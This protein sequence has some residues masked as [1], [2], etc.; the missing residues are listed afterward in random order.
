MYLLKEAA[1]T[2]DKERAQKSRPRKRRAYQQR[3]DKSRDPDE[4]EDEDEPGLTQS[5]QA[6]VIRQLHDSRM[7]K[8]TWTS[9]DPSTQ[10]AWDTIVDKDKAAILSYAEQRGAKHAQDKTPLEANVHEGEDHDS[11]D[12]EDEEKGSPDTER[13][14]NVTEGSKKRDETKGETHPGDKKKRV[15]HN[16]MWKAH[17]HHQTSYVPEAFDPNDNV[18]ED[19][20]PNGDEPPEFAERNNDPSSSDGSVDSGFHNVLDMI[21]DYWGGQEGQFFQ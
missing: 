18:P 7:D 8:E 2:I 6:W 3:L 5:F 11:S 1:K 4:G 15:A 19:F 16:V 9:L 13:Q 14:A 10:K 17:T 20:D 12:N 21:D